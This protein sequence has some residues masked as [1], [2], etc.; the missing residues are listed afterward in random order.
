M[1]TAVVVTQVRSLMSTA[2]QQITVA[3][4]NA[5]VRRALLFRSD[6]ELEI[7]REHATS[8][9][10]AADQATAQ[11]TIIAAVKAVLW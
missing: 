3:I 7:T 5:M 10:S 9:F 8:G 4:Q 6:I 11:A 2:D 1:T